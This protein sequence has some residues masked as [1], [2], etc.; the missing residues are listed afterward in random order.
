MRSFSIAVMAVI[1]ISSL[2]A[3]SGI[4]SL[5]AALEKKLQLKEYQTTIGSLQ[6][7]QE[8]EIE[9]DKELNSAYLKLMKELKGETKI[10]FQRAQK[11]W[12]VFRDMQFKAF[13]AIS[14]RREFGSGQGPIIA[15]NRMKMVR[16]RAVQLVG[17]TN[18]LWGPEGTNVE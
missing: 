7:Y 4:K 12:M 3:Q 8:F 9:Y 10:A 15:M 6:L 2:T 14:D 1:S 18:G 13:E 5:D 17:Y 11:S 16:Q